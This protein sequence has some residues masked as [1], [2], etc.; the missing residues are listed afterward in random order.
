MQQLLTVYRNEAPHA[1]A[2]PEKF[3]EMLED[4]DWRFS[5]ELEGEARHVYI[6]RRIN[7]RVE[8][9]A[10]GSVV[11]GLIQEG[12]LFAA[13]LPYDM[14]KAHEVACLAWDNAA[15]ASKWLQDSRTPKEKRTAH[16]QDVLTAV[17]EA[18]A[19]IEEVA[20]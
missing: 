17:A 8:S 9:H 3:V 14:G 16:L 1:V 11:G 15:K 20:P 2:E 19:R 10:C 18:V 6:E 13:H 7:G 4:Y 5:M 12:K